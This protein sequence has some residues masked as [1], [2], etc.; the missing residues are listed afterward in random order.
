MAQEIAAEIKDAILTGRTPAGTK[1]NQ[2]MLAKQFQVSTT[3]IREAL[4]ALEAQGLVKIDS[5][6][7][8][9]VLSPTL[10][11]MTSL[12][13]IRLA[14]CPLVAESVVGRLT[15]Q[16][17]IRAAEANER[18]VAVDEGSD[19]LE[20]NRDFHAALDETIGDSRLATL[21]EEL[22]TVSM[23]YVNMSLPYREAAQQGA[24]SEHVSLLEAY[25]SGGI[26]RVSFLL[27]EHLTN[28]FNGCKMAMMIR[29]QHESEVVAL[30]S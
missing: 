29:Q 28:T 14:L 4:R 18:L 5:Y 6:T 16:Q 3:P 12:Y 20:A 17:L 24:Y 23:I 9:S 26:A 11:D 15:Q 7:G 21:W 19:W 22:G 1:L 27:A 10:E 30:P 8:A 25:T 13:N 2:L